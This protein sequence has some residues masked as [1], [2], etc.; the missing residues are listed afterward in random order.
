MPGQIAEISDED[1]LGLISPE[2]TLEVREEKPSM[3]P[4]DQEPEDIPEA[5]EEDVLEVSEDEIPEAA[6]E[7]VTEA[8][9]HDVEQ[10]GK[11]AYAALSLTVGRIVSVVNGA[12]ASGTSADALR[13]LAKRIIA[14]PPGAEPLANVQLVDSARDAARKVLGEVTSGL[15]GAKPGVVLPLP[16]SLAELTAAIEKMLEPI[17]K[18]SREVVIKK[19]GNYWI[20]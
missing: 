14:I 8:P 12:G 13:A 20:M 2:D 9:S 11:A 16:P 19:S 17:K 3:Q 18:A 7:D 10:Q 4:I 15:S 6:E 1:F 5:A